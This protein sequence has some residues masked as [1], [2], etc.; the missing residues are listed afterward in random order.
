MNLTG[1]HRLFPNSE[2]P[3]RG[4]DIKAG[5][6]SVPLLGAEGALDHPLVGLSETNF[7]NGF[8]K[9]INGFGPVGMDEV[10]LENHPA[11]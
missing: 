7:S 8:L 5:P 9:E 11:L 10:G 1:I 2:P 3:R 4:L 6:E